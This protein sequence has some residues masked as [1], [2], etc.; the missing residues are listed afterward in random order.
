MPMRPPWAHLPKLAVAALILTVNAWGAAQEKAASPAA[1]PPADNKPAEYVGSTTCQTCHE[2]IFNAFQKNPHQSV[3]TSKKRGWETKACESCHGPGS[4]HAESATATDIQ[5][6]A[7][8]KPAQT[9]STC[10]KCH[11]N[12]PTHAG[13]LQSSHAKNEVSCVACHSI[14][15]NGPNGLVARK[16]AEVN[17]QCAGCHQAQWAS[18]NRPYKHRL[19]EGAM[20]C[21][22]CHNPHGSL[23]PKMMQTVRSN[24]PGCLKC[25]GD[26]AGPFTFQH[27]PMKLEGCG[28]CH[29]PHGSANPKMLTRQDVRF[30]CLECHSNLPVPQPAATAPLGT[31]PPGFH[32]L[33]SPRYQNCTLCHIKV[34]GSYVDRALTK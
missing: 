12:Q 26:K 15:K 16:P 19:P 27:A 32:D 8:L 4:R 31:V 11:L 14:H 25:H 1:P 29:E 18:F 21:V 20:S 30:V 24:E 28:A 22:D 5:N 17:A 7:K 6:P 34:H 2:D 10:L 9:D 33:R 3:E 23:Q 13:R